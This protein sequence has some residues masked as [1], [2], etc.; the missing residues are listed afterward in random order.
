[1][2]SGSARS[3]TRSASKQTYYTILLLAD[4]DRVEDA[5][6]SYA[7]LR[8]VDDV[9]DGDCCSA[10]ERRSFLQRQ[11][12]LL[13]NSYAGNIPRTE[14]AEEELLVELVDNDRAPDSGLQCYL[15]TM[16][17]VMD[18]DAGRRGRLISRAELN[19]YTRWLAVAVTEN[20]HHFIGHGDHA[21][22]EES[23]YLAVSAAHITHMLRDTFDDMQAGYYNIPREVLEASHIGLQDVHSQPYR[24]WIKS[25][26]ELA[27]GHFQA[28]KRYLAHVRSL[29]HRLAVLCYA[30]R[31]EWL[32][33]S[34]ET[35]GYWLRPE[36]ARGH[37]AG[38]A[39]KM[40]GLLISSML[41]QPR[42][43]S[44]GEYGASPYLDKT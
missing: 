32:L 29:R 4:R 11:R 26:V 6:R 28:G 24:D 18:F 31:F 3:I 27:R 20:I 17:M 2:S 5:F 19:T 37:N 22:R 33:E 14:T 42:G 15:R 10:A 21:P 41:E 13:E 7:Y 34:L 39:V 16:M 36:Y 1:M 40:L 12:D 9:L 23:R 30:S 38:T 43:V 25:R 35:D 44:Q 8:W